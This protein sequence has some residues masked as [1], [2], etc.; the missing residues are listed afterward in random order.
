L[1]VDSDNIHAVPLA[2]QQGIKWIQYREKRRTKKEIF[3]KALELRKLTDKFN[4]CLI[5]NDYVDVALS[6]N[7]D[8]VHLGQEDLPLREAKKI[9][10]EKII[11]IS[12][13]NLNEALNAENDGADYIGFGSIF[14][15][16]TKSNIIVQG[17]NRL[18][19][20]VYS[21]KIPIIAIGGITVNNVK[22]VFE[23]GCF[24]VAASSG[25]LNGDIKE[26][27]SKFLSSLNSYRPP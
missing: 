21:V 20:I 19:E 27:I 10:G 4:A 7:A 8:G 17:L 11:G 13:H 6:I 25:L 1:I 9:I 5:I 22:S 24:G 2:L 12:T 14:P 15:T 3:S 18:K 16:D 23:T 26:N